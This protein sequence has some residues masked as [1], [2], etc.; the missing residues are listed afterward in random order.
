MYMQKCS[1][2]VKNGYV[3]NNTAKRKNM[4]CSSLKQSSP[5][6][7]EIFLQKMTDICYT[8][9]SNFEAKND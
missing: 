7:Y 2:S 5:T 8:Q 9:L 1:N 6:E 4:K 3:T